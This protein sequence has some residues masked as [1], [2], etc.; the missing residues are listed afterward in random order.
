M[1]IIVTYRY[2]ERE[3]DADGEV[4]NGQHVRCHELAKLKSLDELGQ[5]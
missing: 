1:N 3:V 4:G 2:D 5:L